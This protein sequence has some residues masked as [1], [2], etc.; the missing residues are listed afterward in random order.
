MNGRGR[1]RMGF[2]TGSAATAAAKAA[3]LVLA[4]RLMPRK[5]SIPC[6][7]GH[8]RLV[9]P[10]RLLAS[11]PERGPVRGMGQEVQ[12]LVHKDGGDDPDSTQGAGI[13]VHAAMQAAAHTQIMVRGGRGVGRVTRPG[14]PV[15]VGQAAINPAPLR[16]IRR[17]LL[18]T[19]AGLGLTA[20]VCVEVEVR[21]G[22][23]LAAQTL[24]PRLGIVGGISILGT[25]GTVIAFSHKAWKDTIVQCL[26]VAL[27]AGLDSV[28]LSTGGRGQRFLEAALPEL[29][30]EGF[31]QAG[32]H[33]GFALRQAARRGLRR[34]IWGGFWGKLVKMAQGRPQTH[35]RLFAVDLPALAVWAA[36]AG[37]DPALCRAV[38]RAN[39]ARH[40]LELV[41]ASS[42]FPRLLDA[43]MH[44]AMGHCRIWAGAPVDLEVLLFDY[45]GALLGRLPR[46]AP[47]ATRPASL[48]APRAGGGPAGS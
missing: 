45:D 32:D 37:I 17:A 41:R 36:R 27:A 10:V 1:V 38:A 42:C 16:Q 39:T 8:V 13:V 9:I 43:V 34:L 35:A 46:E 33:P 5:V 25:R 28:A 3:L 11:D 19:L 6:P 4:G 23:R 7:E 2:T 29:A 26:D 24:N 44:A 40:A 12:V 18:E 20:R 22:Q 31:I 14:L 21:D 15:P 48:A 30:G 47:A